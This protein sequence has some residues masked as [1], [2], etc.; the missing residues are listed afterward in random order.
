MEMV[1]SLDI[2]GYHGTPVPNAFWK[3]EQPSGR[4]AVAFP[5][6]G[7]TA[8]MPVLYYPSHLVRERGY[9]LLQMKTTY[10]NIPEYKNTSDDEQTTWI[11]ADAE[12]SLAAGL[13][14]GDY[15][16]II[17]IGKSLG[18]M[19]VAYLLKTKQD[20]PETKVIWLTPVLTDE[21]I[22]ERLRQGDHPGLLAIGK[23]DPYYDP[24]ILFELEGKANLRLC[25][26]ESANH[27]LEIPGD[28][29]GSLRIMENLVASIDPFLFQ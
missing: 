29:P 11:Y 4:L 28:I 24:N 12:A 20:L 23:V 19:E 7:Y 17:L 10:F 26:Y 21:T 8:D 14:Q 1:K 16:Q 3:H 13:R 6:Y 15:R 2:L 25:V 18:T 9:D 27:S 5:G 22:L